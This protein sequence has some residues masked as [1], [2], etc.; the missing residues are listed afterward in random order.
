MLKNTIFA[1]IE[2]L[3]IATIIHLTGF[4]K[5]L[6]HAFACLDSNVDSTLIQREVLQ[7]K[8]YRLKKCIKQLTKI[9]Q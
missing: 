2:I 1:G 4:I 7:L 5:V 3:C 8:E 9:L 6:G